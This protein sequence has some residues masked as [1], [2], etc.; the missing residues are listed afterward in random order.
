MLSYALHVHRVPFTNVL[1]CLAVNAITK[2]IFLHVHYTHTDTQIHTHTHARTR[3][4]THTHTH[5]NAH[6]HTH[7]QTHAHTHTHTH[8]H[9]Q[10]YTHA[11]THTHTHPHSCP[12]CSNLPLI[13]ATW[14]VNVSSP[15]KIKTISK[16]C[17]QLKY[18]HS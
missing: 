10:T 3:T 13:A 14:T 4:H 5:A 7:T 16:S 11:H 9:T 1:F 2:D 15:K 17:K 18:T 8:A 6:T 12:G